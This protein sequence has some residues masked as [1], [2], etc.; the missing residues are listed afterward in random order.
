MRAREAREDVPA[1]FLLPGMSLLP[2]A[3]TLLRSLWVK[4]T[5]TAL[6]RCDGMHDLVLMIFRW[7]EAHGGRG[8]FDFSFFH[9]HNLW[10]TGVFIV[11]V[12]HSTLDRT[13]TFVRCA[14][15]RGFLLAF[16][17]FVSRIPFWCGPSVFS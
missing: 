2:N 6:S 4:R 1:F 13:P 8:M 11:Q 5:D 10:H 3:A 7:V 17:Y 9:S 15:E 16:C 12:R 14:G